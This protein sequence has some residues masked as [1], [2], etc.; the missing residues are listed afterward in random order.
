MPKSKVIKAPKKYKTPVLQKNGR[1]SSLDTLHNP[2]TTEKNKKLIKYANMRAIKNDSDYSASSSSSDYGSDSDD[3]KP[4]IIV[5]KKN[6]N[7]DTAIDK[8]IKF[9]GLSVCAIPTN[10]DQLPK[11]LLMKEGIIPSYSTFNIIVGSVG[12]GKSNLL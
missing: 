11:R 5:N 9:N 1:I 4:E 6:I 3:F 12:S 7:P 2:W 10:K 8:N